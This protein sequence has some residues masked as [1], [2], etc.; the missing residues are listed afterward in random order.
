M[1]IILA[2]GGKPQ[3]GGIEDALAQIKAQGQSLD[4]VMELLAGLHIQP[5]F[6]AHPTEST[7]RTQLRRW[8]R[9][10]CGTVT[11]RRRA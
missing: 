11:A 7:R 4:Q 9:M 3:P 2:D 5:I 8:Q 10:A 1:P 6:V